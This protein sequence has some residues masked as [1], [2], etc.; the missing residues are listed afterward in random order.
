MKHAAYENTMVMQVLKV[1]KNKAPIVERQ[2]R[3]YPEAL[4]PKQHEF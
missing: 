1:G 4:K 3:L 2:G